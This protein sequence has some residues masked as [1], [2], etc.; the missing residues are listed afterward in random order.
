LNKGV[1]GQSHLKNWASHASCEVFY[2]VFAGIITESEVIST[3]GTSK[4]SG[5]VTLAI[6][7]SILRNDLQL[8]K[9]LKSA[10]NNEQQKMPLNVENVLVISE[11]QGISDSRIK[12]GAVITVASSFVIIRY[13]LQHKNVRCIN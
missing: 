4:A 6:T 12:S 11:A 7:L 13:S 8:L 2:D 9:R 5:A 1:V 3:D 10:R